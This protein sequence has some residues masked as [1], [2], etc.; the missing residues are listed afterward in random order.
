MDFVAVQ[1]PMTDA[2]KADL[3]IGQLTR[4]GFTGFQEE[5]GSLT[6]FLPQNALE[7]VE[8]ELAALAAAEEVTYQIRP[9]PWQNWNLEWEQSF[10]PIR[11]GTFC[12]IRAVFHA[13]VTGVA[14]EIIITP[15]MT[16][17]TGHHATTASMIRMM[18]HLEFSGRSV[19]DFGTGTGI[20]AILAAR[21][22]AA[23]VIAVD[24]DPQAVENATENAAENGVAD[25]IRFF[26]ADSAG[27]ETRAGEHYDCILANIQLGVITDNLPVLASRLTH[28]GSVIV[29]GMLE[30]DWERLEK[31]A[32][33]CKLVKVR[34]IRDSGWIA[35][36]FCKALE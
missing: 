17:G 30:T 32:S 13:P 31:A 8:A 16:F 26:T 25:R 1:F 4:L 6:A 19:F 28:G 15:R 36:A 10:P 7:G 2:R 20:L 14:H 29:S 5:T 23:P 33:A 27:D 18:E 12:G 3:L 24:N 35:V 34:E 9:I 11:I 21:M 22:G